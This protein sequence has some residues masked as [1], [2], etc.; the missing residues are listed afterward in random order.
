MRDRR[1]IRNKNFDSFHFGHR[2]QLPLRV[3]ATQTVPAPRMSPPHAHTATK[4]MHPAS[5]RRSESAPAHPFLL[6]D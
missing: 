5:R 2:V 1:G 6:T 3:V 4:R